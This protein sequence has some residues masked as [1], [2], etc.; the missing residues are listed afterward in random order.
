MPYICVRRSHDLNHDEAHAMLDELAAK[1]ADKLDLHYH[2][3]G[4]TLRFRRSGADGSIKLTD[5]E[6]IIEANLGIMLRVIKPTLMAAI[7]NTLDDYI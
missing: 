2:K 6:I 7:E 3:D 4:D 1:M 5:S